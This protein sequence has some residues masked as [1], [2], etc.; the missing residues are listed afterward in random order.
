MRFF[1]TRDPRSNSLLRAILF[2][3]LIFSLAFWVT[4]WLFYTRI[5]F[6]YTGMVT[7]YRGAEA[8]FRPPKSFFALVEE[9]HTHA[10]AMMI[11]L[12]T[13]THLLLFTPLAKTW[14]RLLIHG[15]FTTAGLDMISGWLIRYLSPLLAWIKMAS[16]LGFQILLLA[17]MVVFAWHLSRRTQDG[18]HEGR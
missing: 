7:H 12:M 13:W 18:T 5:T 1:I 8:S 15:L 6:T 3:S 16:F 2:W 9:T 17:A 11:F 10:L 4:N 14:K